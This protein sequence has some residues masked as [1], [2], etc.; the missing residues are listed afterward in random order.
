MDKIKALWRATT[1]GVGG[2][3]AQASIVVNVMEETGIKTYTIL[4]SQ[5]GFKE[6]E[7]VF[8]AMTS[9]DHDSESFRNHAAEIISIARK[10]ENIVG[11]AVGAFQNLGAAGGRLTRK[12]NRILFDY[13]PIDSTL[14]Q[15]VLHVLDTNDAE[16]WKPL[17]RFIENLYSNTTEYVRQQ[18]F[19]WLRSCFDD[20]STSGF[21]ITE[22]GCFIGYK[23]CM[24]IDGHPASINTGFGIVNGAESTGHLDNS[25]GNVVE[26][27]RRMVTDDPALACSKGLHVGTWGY[28][29]AFSEGYVLKVKVDPADVVSIPE[30]CHAQKLRC[31]RY[32]V[33]SV[34]ETPTRDVID[35]DDD[36]YDDDDHDDYDDDD[37]YENDDD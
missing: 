29:S 31:C 11:I 37:F 13:E 10:N 15:T 32:K 3:P 27:P 14:E 25:I 30:D 34:V 23:G 6:I 26:M 17:L 18:L 12:G 35:H 8:K 20:S 9:E 21:P 19:S 2:K 5:V 4:D 24:R 22:D 7:A 33:L 1:P 16:N 28:A 36:D